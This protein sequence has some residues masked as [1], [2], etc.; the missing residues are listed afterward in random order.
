MKI[1]F[2]A[3]LLG[4]LG[5]L[6]LAQNADANGQPGNIDVQ[7]AAISSERNRL[8]ADFLREDAACYKKF[9][10]NNC[11]NKVNVRRREAI[12]VL[13]Q[14]EIALNDEERRIK[15]EDQLRKTQDKVSP[16]NQKQASDSRAK[17]T[18]E[19]L[20]RLEREKDK[21][22]ERTN[23]QSNEKAALAANAERLL[24]HQKKNQTRAENQA[25][26]AEEAQK[27]NQRQ[28]EAQERRAQ[29]DAEE[30]KRVKPAANPLPIPE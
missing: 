4:M 29:H 20:G 13:R 27:F 15:G 28:I 17:A 3:I 7:R 26:D 22:Q 6:S 12:A 14:K 2:I 18:K 23:R 5:D 21:T 30:K 10:V 8:E 11:L 25:G 16:E 1:L 19:S 9:A 24:A